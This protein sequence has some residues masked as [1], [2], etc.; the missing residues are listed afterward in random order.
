MDLF[1]P[2]IGNDP[3]QT[4]RRYTTPESNRTHEIFFDDD[5]DYND[6]FDSSNLI[7][8]RADNNRNNTI[9]K[10]ITPDVVESDFFGEFN[11]KFT[12]EY[13]VSCVVNTP[14]RQLVSCIA[15]G[16]YNEFQFE[17][18]YVKTYHQA[19]NGM[20]Y[21]W[22]LSSLAALKS[23]VSVGYGDEEQMKNQTDWIRNVSQKMIQA[24]DGFHHKIPLSLMKKKYLKHY[25]QPGTIEKGD[26]LIFLNRMLEC[27]K[28]EIIICHEDGLRSFFIATRF[29]DNNDSFFAFGY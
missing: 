6:Q 15:G 7:M 18:E 17:Y 1:P 9:Y 27:I 25:L 19:V 10:V 12:G 29:D 13:H 22:R 8:G 11:Y 24:I 28:Y 4:I 26:E 5:D 23:V 2:T 3:K 21:Q 20:I 16:G 14:N